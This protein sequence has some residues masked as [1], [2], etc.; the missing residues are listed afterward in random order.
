[1][2]TAIKI[3]TTE[4]RSI[5]H[6][7][8]QND[9]KVIEKYVGHDASIDVDYLILS[10]NG[11]KIE[12]GWEHMDD[13][14]IKCKDETFKFLENLVKHNFQYGKAEVLNNKMKL[15][16]KPLSFPTRLVVNKSKLMDDFFYFNENRSK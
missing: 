7:L 10:K 16:L 9:W 5:V 15:F 3:E 4:W 6:Y 12:L 14:E 1:M 11:I 13:G 2:K 8:Y